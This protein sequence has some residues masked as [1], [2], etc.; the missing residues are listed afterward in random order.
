[1]DSHGG[2]QNH[3]LG[4][5]RHLGAQG[6]RPQL[7]APG[8]L[9]DDVRDRL[10][11]STF[12][13]A[14]ASVPVPY[15]GSVA[16]VSFGPL[17]AARVRSWLR[18]G[19]FDLL[20]VH[21][22]ITPSISLLALALAETPV[23]A[24]YHTATPRSRT[25]QVAGRTLAGLVAKIDA[26]IAV[27]ETARAVVVQHLGRDALVVPN[28]FDHAAYAGR[29]GA[30]AARWRGG[31][32][33]RV[34]FLGRLDEPRKGVDV[35]LAAVPAIRA[36]R[37]EVEVVVA[38][39]GSRALPSGVTGRGALSEGDK[40]A[41][42]AG[43]DV[44]VAPHLA[45]E[46]FGI[47]LLEA[48]ASGAAVVASDLPAFADVLHGGPG[49][50]LGSLV[51]PGDPDALAAAVLAA[52]DRG[53]ATG[54]EA[55]QRI[56]RYDWS[57]VG[58]EIAAVYAAVLGARRASRAGVQE[59]AT[60]SRSARR[61]RGTWTALDGALLDRAQMVRELVPDSEPARRAA[62]S[63]A[64]VL[65]AESTSA[66]REQAESELSH[67]LGLLG[68]QVAPEHARAALHRR[69]HNDAVAAARTRRRARRTQAAGDAARPFE[70][71]DV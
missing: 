65:R 69:L 49:T 26:G 35:L 20:H 46:S 43:T 17:T 22:P 29:S 32:R 4:L 30:D 3:V 59:A 16:R 67:A 56:A 62:R 1:M 54:G 28:G 61:V 71:V 25:M 8:R 47:V 18:R 70:M 24:T 13:S 6:H 11:E 10:G 64:T 7:L 60:P 53:S 50:P 12:C 21:E 33:P 14:G 36:A 23:V 40:R 9:A 34:S 19:R 39:L 42:L 45:R 57:V 58:S 48:L 44:F 38:G 5:A 2:V 55:R 27:S 51:P 52:L 41:L 63:A 66:E 68:L 37:P 31:R 15:N